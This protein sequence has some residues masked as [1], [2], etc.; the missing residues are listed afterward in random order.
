MSGPTLTYPGDLTTEVVGEIKGPTLHGEFL[1]AIGATFRMERG[2][3]AQTVVEYAYGV[4][5]DLC[6]GLVPEVDL[7]SLARL[8]RA[9]RLS[10]R[11][12]HDVCPP[13]EGTE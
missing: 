13:R 2:Q 6:A 3:P 5:C 4:R 9:T 8:P 1:T 12:R 11:V 7:A 10:V